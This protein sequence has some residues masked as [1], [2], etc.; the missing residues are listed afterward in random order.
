[1]VCR[2]KQEQAASIQTGECLAGQQIDPLQLQ[3][4]DHIIDMFEEY[5]ERLLFISETR[6]DMD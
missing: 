2:N 1:M 4:N 3:G 5:P 6:P